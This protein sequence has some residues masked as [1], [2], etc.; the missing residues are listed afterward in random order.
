MERPAVSDTV[1]DAKINPETGGPQKQ[2]EISLASDYLPSSHDGLLEA[3]SRVPGTAIPSSKKTVSTASVAF[4]DNDEVISQEGEALLD[5][6]EDPTRGPEPAL[7][8]GP[9][10]HLSSES[11]ELASTP[12]GTSGVSMRDFATAATKPAL[13]SVPEDAEVDDNDDAV[14]TA[15]GVKAL[16]RRYSPRDDDTNGHIH[17]PPLSQPT[18]DESEFAQKQAEAREALIRLQL[19]LNENFL[20]KPSPTS[21]STRSSHPKHIYSF[22]D[23]RP[24]APSSIFP[25]VRES[26]PT[27]LDA[28]AAP[29]H[30][31][32]AE[33]V[34]TSYHHMATVSQDLQD[35]EPRDETMMRSMSKTETKSERAG[36]GAETDLNGPGPSIINDAPKQPL[37]LPPPLHL[38]DH[39]FQPRFHLPQPVVPPSPGEISL[40]N[41]P[42]P[43]SSPR[44]SVQRPATAS[45]TDRER[46]IP[47]PA[48]Q[49][50]LQY[51]FPSTPGMNERI[52][53]RQS[54]IRSQASST[55]QF[56]IPYHMIPDRSSSVRDRSVMEDDDE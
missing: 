43:V 23:G 26:S 3:Q 48:S 38:T 19:S 29:D 28:Q 55:S 13:T 12:S 34:E 20:T 42:I 21:R 27:L 10:I 7:P 25:Q 5:Q 8:V 52:L 40:S 51:P 17:P 16:P 44:Q 1:Q 14:S 41:F 54:S 22:S 47:R 18:F 50:A 45:P 56:S 11:P 31:V 46:A 24:A 39:P 4:L 36:H 6:R 37:P 35:A 2:D 15:N 9:Y 33:R 49:N 32:D 30:S 53:R